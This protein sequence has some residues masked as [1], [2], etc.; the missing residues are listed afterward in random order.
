MSIRPPRAGTRVRG[1]SGDRGRR[2]RGRQ[3]AVLRR[4]AGAPDG[5]IAYWEAIDGRD[6]AR[7]H[8]GAGAADGG[9]V[10]SVPADAVAGFQS[11]S[12]GRRPAAW[13]GHP[14]YRRPVDACRR[15]AVP[16]RI[17][18]RSLPAGEPRSEHSVVRP[19]SDG[20]AAR[21]FTGRAGPHSSSWERMSGAASRSGRWRARNT[22]RSICAALDARIR[23]PA[24]AA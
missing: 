20:I 12:A 2:S 5:P 9:L 8:Q 15:G 14:P 7:S 24:T 6:R 13:R 23:P 19:S 22:R 10:R 3:C 21:R 4:L 1:I 18:G 11:R 17:D 16:R